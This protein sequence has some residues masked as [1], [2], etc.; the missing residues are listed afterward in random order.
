[1]TPVRPRRSPQAVLA[2]PRLG[3]RSLQSAFTNARKGG[4]S[5]LACLRIVGRKEAQ[6]GWR[7]EPCL[8]SVFQAGAE[9]AVISPLGRRDRNLR[10]GAGIPSCEADARRELRFDPGIP[11][12]LVAGDQ[13]KEIQGHLVVDGDAP[14]L[15]AWHNSADQILESVEPIGSTVQR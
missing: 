6:V 1:M 9:G 5:A 12:L 8:A 13:G 2:V 11:N 4:V 7:S 14:K 15:L 3:S 10:R